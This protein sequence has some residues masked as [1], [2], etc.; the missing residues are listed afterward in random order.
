MTS[1]RWPGSLAHSTAQKARKNYQLYESRM[2]M[3]PNL[4]KTMKSAALEVHLNNMS[5]KFFAA[6]SRNM[7]SRP[8]FRWLRQVMVF[9]R[10]GHWKLTAGE[11]CWQSFPHRAC[12]PCRHRLHKL[13]AWG[14]RKGWVEPHQSSM[15][16]AHVQTARDGFLTKH[17]SMNIN[18]MV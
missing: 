1:L 8:R 3:E 5:L 11:S 16:W 10:T 6:V 7:F 17:E 2:V 12:H 18:D 13:N 9:A 15:I 4:E 14:F